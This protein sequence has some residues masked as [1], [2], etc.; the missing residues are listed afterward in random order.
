MCGQQKCEPSFWD[1]FI[2]CSGRGEE[3]I[4]YRLFQLP[5]FSAFG[6]ESRNCFCGVEWVCFYDCSK[7]KKFS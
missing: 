6:T 3:C 7:G 2:A 4:D 1:P 5:Q